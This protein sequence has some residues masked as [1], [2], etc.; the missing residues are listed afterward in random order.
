M[1]YHLEN[2]ARVVVHEATMQVRHNTTQ[3]TYYTAHFLRNL[4]PLK[5]LDHLC[6]ARTQLV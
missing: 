5:K 1:C 2:G 4:G 3:H 6:C